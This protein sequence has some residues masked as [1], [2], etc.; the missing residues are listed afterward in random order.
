MTVA[1]A[2]VPETS[3]PTF[4]IVGDSSLARRV[5]ASM[6]DRGS[7]V[8]HLG[9][10]GDQALVAALVRRPRAVA[11]LVRDDVAALRYS[12]A[13][14]HLDPTVP[15]VVTI[16]DRT[17][18]SQLAGFLPQ[19]DITSLADL[20]V[21]ALAG[22]CL[23]RDT[24]AVSRA[25]EAGASVVT[26]RGPH[27]PVSTRGRIARR[28]WRSRVS[29]FSLA[30]GAHDPGTRLLLWG[31]VGILGILVTDWV[32]LMTYQHRSAS[33]AFLE[34]TRVVATV[35]PAPDDAD[36]A[37]AVLAGVAMLVTIV[38]TAMFTAGLVDRLLG[39]ALLG[40]T[41]PTSVPRADHVIVVG[42]GQ[43][44]VRLCIHLRSLG[45][46]IV[47]V[48]RD[49]TAPQ[50]RVAKAMNIPVVVGHGGDRALLERLGLHRAKALAAVGSNDLD[51]IAV[52]V[53]A[54]GVASTTPIVMRA[55]E[56][57]AIAETRSLMPLGVSRDVN[58]L[59]ATYVVGRLIG[60]RANSVVTDGA[61]VYLVGE[62]PTFTR[63]VV[64]ARDDCLHRHPAASTSD[65][66]GSCTR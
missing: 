25:A 37:Y 52:A 53:A 57:E 54:H 34:A 1:S 12:L 43:V 28:T 33:E 32:W 4:L 19:A 7:S 49:A 36:R 13:V 6:V 44:G 24:L 51:N 64:G 27:G 10:P 59:A 22:P 42:L 38:L 56:Q 48:E 8:T 63:L 23:G 18:A 35:G 2:V 20:A 31:L 3:Q 50:L 29:R 30:L 60:M 47:G 62:G 26:V 55:G 21:P 58:L 45:V 46:E 39:P 41:G 16:F 40:L 5:C 15:L 14:A 65:R 66:C 9:S 61:H 17:M 11:V